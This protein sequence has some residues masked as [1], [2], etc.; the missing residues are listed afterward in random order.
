MTVANPTEIRQWGFAKET[1]RGTAEAAPTDFISVTK[2][3]EVAHALKLIEDPALRGVNA[4]YPSFAGMLETNGVLKT[5]FRAQNHGQFLHMLF[6]TPTSDVEQASFVVTASSN[7][8]IDFNIG[9]SNLVATIAAGTYIAGTNQATAASL[10]KAVYDAIVA[11]EAVGTYTVSYSTATGLFTIARSSGTFQMLFLTGPNTART[12]AAL[13]GYAVVDKTGSTS[14]AGTVVQTPPFK[15]L[16][17]QAGVIQPPSYTLFASRGSNVTKKQYNLG[18]AAK[19]KFTGIAEGPVE[20][21]AAVMA[22]FEATYGGSWSPTYTE[23]PVL[24]FNNTTVKFAGSAPSVPNV[25]SWSLEIGNGMKAYRPLSQQQYPQDYLAAGPFEAMG[26]MIVYFHDE[27]ERA[28]FLAATQTSLEFL[29]AGSVVAGGTVKYTLDILLPS[30]EYEAFAF[31][32]ENGFLGA[33]VK[34]RARYSTGSAAL[35]ICYVI[36]YKVSY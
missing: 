31:G 7:D 4:R 15:H 20:L 19:L 33:K 28:K 34:F 12:I 26:D 8:R 23:S 13:L 16:F 24:M 6:G 11:A 35:A 9:A 17:T 18:S 5:P 3:S 1:V 25:Q 22:Q 2:D 36:N 21:E 29:I 10:C 32:D 30:V 27:T 14:Y